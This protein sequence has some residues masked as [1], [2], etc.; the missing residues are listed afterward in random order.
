[1]F[2][3]PRQPS[4]AE[5]I[6]YVVRGEHAFVA[7]DVPA[8]R[9]RF[10]SDLCEALADYPVKVINALEAKNN[11]DFA[12]QVVS[13][14]C[15]L[16]ASI[17]SELSVAPLTLHGYLEATM[18]QFREKDKKGYLIV[19]CIDAVIER[20]SMFEVE[21]AFRSAMQRY[22]D[23][24]IVWLASQETIIAI[25]QSDRPFYLSFRNFGL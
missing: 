19:N 5:A 12:S 25:N 23:V 2:D 18:L 11:Q 1:M 13:A 15:E 10:V 24:A 9:D 6:P 7:I 17:D 16:L 4:F 14:C 20:Q 22:D 3:N 21:G 8:E